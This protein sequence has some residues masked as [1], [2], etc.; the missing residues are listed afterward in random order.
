M[1]ASMG[2]ADVREPGEEGAGPE[3]ALAE[4]LARGL[5]PAFPERKVTALHLAELL[6]DAVE[7]ALQLS[8]GNDPAPALAGF[9]L[10]AT[11]AD[12]FAWDGPPGWDEVLERGLAPGRPL[13]PGPSPLDGLGRGSSRIEQR[14]ILVGA[15]RA[16]AARLVEAGRTAAALDGEGGGERLVAAHAALLR[17]VG[18]AAAAPCLD[19]APDADASAPGPDAADALCAEIDSRAAAGS[20]FAAAQ[21]EWLARLSADNPGAGT[22]G[23]RTFFAGISQVP[24]AALAARRFRDEARAGRLAAGCEALLGAV[25]GFQPVRWTQLRGGIP[26]GWI[27]ALCPAPP[28]A[29]RAIERLARECHAALDLAG[30][31][32]FA[33]GLGP[34][35]LTALGS[36]F[37][38]RCAQAVA[39]WEELR[40]AAPRD[41]TPRT[42]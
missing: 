24:R 5:D 12:V 26:A 16:G 9:E 22:A 36:L 10:L 33:R 40:T 32:W 41:Q 25:G 37:T 11:R 15:A 38:A 42:P 34:F 17:L 13:A 6:L 7:C 23:F 29:E 27:A 28:P 2:G 31:L 35:A 18:I 8:E 1:L 21:E 39:L 19:L 4:S 3:R 30:R 20:D 14:E